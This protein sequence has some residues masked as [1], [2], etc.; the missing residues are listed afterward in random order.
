MTN[1]RSKISYP[2]LIRQFDRLNRRIIHL[3]SQLQRRVLH[4]SFV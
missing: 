2:S 1:A 4:V 3:L